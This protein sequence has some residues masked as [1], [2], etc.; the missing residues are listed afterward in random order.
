MD[1][2]G[3]YMYMIIT[4]TV[5]LISMSFKYVQIVF[6]LSDQNSFDC[7]YCLFNLCINLELRGQ[8]FSLREIEFKDMCFMHIYFCFYC[9]I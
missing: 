6:T 7:D 3:A 1:L 5:G 8:L 4:Y 9:C 2:V